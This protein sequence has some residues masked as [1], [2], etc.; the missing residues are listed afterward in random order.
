[1]ST[2]SG[3]TSR[4]IRE[5]AMKRYPLRLISLLT[6][7]L[8]TIGPLRAQELAPVAGFFQTVTGNP[9][10]PS[11]TTLGSINSAVLQNFGAGAVTLQAFQDG[12]NLANNAGFSWR[13]GAVPGF[14]SQS[15][16]TPGVASRIDFNSG[17]T[18]AAFSAAGPQLVFGGQSLATGVNAAQIMIGDN[19]VISINQGGPN[20]PGDALIVANQSNILSAGYSARNGA[21]LFSIGL[22]PAAIQGLA[23][24]QTS[25]GVWQRA[26]GQS[27]DF[28]L[29]NLSVGVVG[30]TGVI[31]VGQGSIG[32]GASLQNSADVGAVNASA[33]INALNQT[34]SASV[35]QIGGSPLAGGSTIT[36]R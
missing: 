5:A 32:T 29:N 17:N 3:R 9:F 10:F 12:A 25:G 18:L 1:M 19:T 7:T 24:A 27:S 22:G 20:G 26:G 35:N 15:I 4:A 6:L 14:L 31:S 2:I 16:G 13:A 11:A 8:A 36:I 21:G 28:S 30:G 34:N 33:S 23:P